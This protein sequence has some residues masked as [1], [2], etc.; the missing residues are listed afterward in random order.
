MAGTISMAG[1]GSGMDV[2]GLVDALVS[3]ESSTKTQLQNRLTQTNAAS[4]SISDISSLLSKL[5]TTTDALATPEKAQSY[6]ATSSDTAISASVT[7]ATSAARYSVNV[8]ALAQ[9]YRAYSTTFA[10]LSTEVGEANSG[11]MSIQ[12]GSDTATSFDISSTDTLSS[13]AG[14]INSAGIGVT[15]TTIYDGSTFRL[16]VRS[17]E[18]GADNKVTI[19]GSDLGLN[20]A[21]NIKQQAQDAHIVVDGIDIYSKSNV[22]TGA[23]PGVSLT[24]S[25]TTTAAV[26]LKV[27]ADSSSLKTKVQSFVD[28]YNAVVKKVHTVAGYGDTAASVDL[29]SGNSN[30]RGLSNRMTGAFRSVISTGN[31]KYTSMNSIGI[32]TSSDGTLT[33]DSTKFNNAVSASPQ[34]VTQILAGS[35]SG[36]GVMDN[37]TSLVKSFT[38]NDGLLTNQLNTI[39]SSIKRLNDRIDSQDNYL[40]KYRAR[41]EKQFSAMDTSVSASNNTQSY[42]NTYLS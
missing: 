19:T 13:I 29:L 30:L 8:S 5:K 14:K 27:D 7:T 25:K 39:K 36:D 40:T 35:S 12:L 28:A 16:Q 1:L 20:I 37:M 10:T 42:L 21:D 6:S 32:S 24:L 22:V 26:D 34:A 38:N 23:I 41:L 3:A 9:E 17:K 2:N 18:V 15:A 31:E 11:T 33:L 4:T